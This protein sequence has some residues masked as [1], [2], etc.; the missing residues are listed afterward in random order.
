MY[1][2]PPPGEDPWGSKGI[3]QSVNVPKQTVV[4]RRWDS[5]ILKFGF[6]KRVDKG[7]IT[8]VKDLES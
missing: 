6:N 8:S 5:E 7:R 3:R 2:R 1:L 4:L